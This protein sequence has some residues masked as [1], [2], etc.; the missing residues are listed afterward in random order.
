NLPEDNRILF[1]PHN[2]RHLQR[3]L[4]LHQIA[5]VDGILADSGVSSHQFDEASRGFSIRFDAAMDMRMARRQEQ[6]AHQIVQHYSEQQLHRWFEQYGQVTNSKTLARTI[7]AI[8]DKV[9]LQTIESFKNAL[10]SVV[11]GNPN[12]Y[13]AQVFQALRIEVNEEL[14]VLEELLQ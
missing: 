11:K 1:I 4:R 5:H 3:C 12:K 13:F 14:V 10:R 9:S 7:V 6:P 8:R 2:F